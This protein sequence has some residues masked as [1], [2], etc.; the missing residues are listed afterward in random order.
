M[1]F[2]YCFLAIA[3][4]WSRLWRGVRCCLSIR[5]RH[6]L[7]DDTPGTENSISEPSRAQASVSV[8]Q[9]VCVKSNPSCKT[10][11]RSETLK[12]PKAIKKTDTQLLVL[13]TNS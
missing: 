11:K 2:P 8:R 5:L 12:R 9:S 13:R 4:T 10:L 7:A 1:A 3:D 6:T